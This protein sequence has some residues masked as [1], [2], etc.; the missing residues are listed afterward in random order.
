MKVLVVGGG[1]RE[2]ALCWK[3]ARSPLLTQLYCTPGNP[4]IARIAT[5]LAGDPLDVALREGIDF[6]V[7]GPEVPLAEG[8]VDRLNAAGVAAFGPTKV[9][10]QIEAS[11]IFCKELLHRHGIPTAG[12]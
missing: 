11:K 3:I 2:H 5:C 8:I 9:A 7:V 1:G 4:G 6:V 10:A 12:L